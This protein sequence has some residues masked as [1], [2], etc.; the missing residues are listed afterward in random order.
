V[1][2]TLEWLL[3]VMRL[4]RGLLIGIFTGRMGWTFYPALRGSL[5]RTPVEELNLQPGELVEVRS[6][7]EIVATL[8]RE[9]RNRG[10]LFDGEM[11]PYCGGIYRVLRRV[12]R[13]INENTGKMMEMK[14]PCIILEGVVCKSDYHR[15]CPRAIH[16]YW[17][18][19]W[20]KRVTPAIQ[21]PAM[22]EQEL[23]ACH[24]H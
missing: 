21:T 22:R 20:L 9:N 17:R 1:G 24:E 7:E 3:A 14:F 23:E 10:L 5:D 15:L 13:I 18:E 16:S 8:N 2:R 4:L 11:T 19:N 6:I 12:H